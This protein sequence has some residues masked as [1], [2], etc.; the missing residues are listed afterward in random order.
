MFTRCGSCN[1]AHTYGCFVKVWL[2]CK[3]T[4]FSFPNSFEGTMTPSSA[5]AALLTFCTIISLGSVGLVLSIAVPEGG[6][7]WFWLMTLSPLAYVPT[8]DSTSRNPKWNLRHRCSNRLS[9]FDGCS[10]GVYYWTKASRKEEIK[11]KMVLSDDGNNV[12]EILVRGDDV[13]VEQMRRELKMSEKGMIYVKGIFET[14]PIA[15]MS[16]V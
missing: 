8:S 2:Q 9:V 6:N 5:Q 7:N 15:L 11:V 13:Q 16:G 3:L 14:W 12:S 10:R 4:Y 1:L